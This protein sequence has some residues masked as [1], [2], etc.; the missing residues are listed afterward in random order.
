MAQKII[1]SIYIE[2]LSFGMF[3][4]PE[5]YFFLTYGIFY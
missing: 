4:V 1:A 5:C 3:I 2:L